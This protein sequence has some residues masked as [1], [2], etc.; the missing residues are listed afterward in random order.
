MNLWAPGFKLYQLFLHVYFKAQCHCW[1]DH[2]VHRCQFSLGPGWRR[3]FPF[4]RSPL[5]SLLLYD[6]VF[7]LFPP[8]RSLVPGLMTVTLWNLR[9][10]L[11]MTKSQLH[12]SNTSS[13]ITNNKKEL[14]K[15]VRSTSFPKPQMKS[16]SIFFKFINPCFL[17][18]L[19]YHICLLLCLSG[20]F[21]VSLDLVPWV[22]EVFSRV[23]RGAS[24]AAGRRHERDRN[25]KP[26]MKSLWHI[27]Y[28]F[29]DR[30]GG[31]VA[32]TWLMRYP[33]PTHPP[34]PPSFV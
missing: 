34:T 33:P 15:T 8:L 28:R 16:V 6:P 9:N 22:P 10:Y 24:S 17:S 13:L 14:W 29:T 11:W 32:L 31:S 19:L 23:R 27:E 30:A 26:R 25:R 1:G 21:T 3:P 2:F 7:C 5:G 20:Y 4:L 12:V 18:Y